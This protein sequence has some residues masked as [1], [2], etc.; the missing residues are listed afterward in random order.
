[1]IQWLK[2][3]TIFH[4]QATS[5][6]QENHPLTHGGRKNQKQIMRQLK[7]GLNFEQEHLRP[8][9]MQSKPNGGAH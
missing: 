1:M 9:G 4:I 2:N 8:Q 3:M 6:N 7:T 5:T